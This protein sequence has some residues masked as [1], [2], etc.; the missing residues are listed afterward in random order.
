MRLIAVAPNVIGCNFD[1]SHL[2]WQQ[3]DPILTIRALG[4][5]IFHVHAKDC[6]IDT[7]NTAL[8]SLGP[9]EGSSSVSGSVMKTPVA[10]DPWLYLAA[11]GLF[12]SVFLSM[13][14]LSGVWRFLLR[15]LCASVNLLIAAARRLSPEERT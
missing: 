3:A 10:L 5:R 12:V 7:A 15:A 4:D 11:R 13:L 2:F 1:P 8:N 9:D 14:V 6:R